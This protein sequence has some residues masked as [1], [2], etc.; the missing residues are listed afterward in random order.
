LLKGCV[1]FGWGSHVVCVCEDVKRL[2]G[3]PEDTPGNLDV[4]CSHP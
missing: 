3:A 4:Q 1:K 2:S